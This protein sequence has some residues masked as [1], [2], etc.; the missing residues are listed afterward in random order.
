MLVVLAV[1]DLPVPVSPSSAVTEICECVSLNSELNRSPFLSP[2]KL[3]CLG[4]FS[5]RDEL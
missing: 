3:V 2:K 5:R 4:G 1:M